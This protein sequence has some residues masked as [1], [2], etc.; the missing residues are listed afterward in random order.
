MTAGALGAYMLA[1]WRMEGR[2]IALAGASRCRRSRSPAAVLGWFATRV[3]LSTLIGE[4]LWPTNFIRV[5]AKT[6][7]D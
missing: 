4:N 6:E 3:G 7:S 1:S 5:G 2:A